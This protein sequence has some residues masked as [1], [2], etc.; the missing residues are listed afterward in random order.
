MKYAAASSKTRPVTADAQA[1]PSTKSGFSCAPRVIDSRSANKN[2][3]VRPSWQMR[4]ISA[5]KSPTCSPS[6]SETSSTKTHP[7][8]ADAW[9]HTSSRA[10][11]RVPSPKSPD[12]VGPYANGRTHSWPTSTPAEPATH[13]TEA[14]NGHYRAGQTH[15]QRLPQP[16]QLPTPNAPHRRRPRRLHPHSTLKSRFTPQILRDAWHRVRASL[17]V[18]VRAKAYPVLSSRFQQKFD[19]YTKTGTPF[20]I[21]R[22][23]NI[24]NR[25][26]KR[27]NEAYPFDVENALFIGIAQKE[28]G[29]LLF[30]PCFS[31]AAGATLRFQ[32]GHVVD[33]ERPSPHAARRPGLPLPHT[34]STGQPGV[35]SSKQIPKRQDRNSQILALHTCTRLD[36]NIVA[37]Q[38]SSAFLFALPN[39]QYSG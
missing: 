38:K 22:A 33:A 4:R 19:F 23:G 26:M 39:A 29:T 30:L 3:S 10:Y 31:Q 2:D 34:F 17:C 6:K 8:K 21:S 15:R 20:L 11:Q 27:L 9:P 16:H 14:I 24:K 36:L 1:I 13:H 35:R 5:S 37:R 25:D 12:W 18:P 7:P 28:P 32:P